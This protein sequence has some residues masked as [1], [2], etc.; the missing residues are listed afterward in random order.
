MAAKEGIPSDYPARNAA[1]V[2]PDNSNDLAH[3]TRALFVGGAGNLNVDTADGD[4]VLFTGVTAG[5]I[6]PL[7][8][9][10]VR[11]TSTTAT[12]IVALW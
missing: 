11:S 5:M 7:A 3:V 2:T 4:T 12:N 6:L 8:V 1:V 10:R 9:K